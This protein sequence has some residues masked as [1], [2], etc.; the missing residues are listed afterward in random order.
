M[1]GLVKKYLFLIVTYILLFNFIHAQDTL[2]NS[3]YFGYG[4]GSAPMFSIILGSGITTMVT[5]GMYEAPSTKTTGIINIGYQHLLSKRFSLGGTYSYEKITL[6]WDANSTSDFQSFS[7]N[8]NTIMASMRYKYTV[9]K[10]VELYGRIDLGYQWYNQSN[11]SDYVV[12][13]SNF[14]FQFTPFGLSYGKN[15]R[16]FFE[17]GFGNLGLINFGINCNF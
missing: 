5:F 4:R 13:F 3:V 2:K 10:P 17:L 6:S 14:G 12:E 11:P 7:D 8:I 9:D 1:P 15:W 16:G